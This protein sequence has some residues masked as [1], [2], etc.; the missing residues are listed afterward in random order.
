M[1]TPTD[2]P[3]APTRPGKD[4]QKLLFEP[5][6]SINGPIKGDSLAPFLT[7]VAE[8]RNAQE[9]LILELNTNGG[10]ADIARRIALEIRLFTR[11]SGRDAYCVGKS[12]VYSAGV[13]IFAAFPIKGRFLTEDAVLLIHERRLEKS[14]ALNGPLR[15]NIQIVR[16]QLSLLE[17]ASK[18]ER[19]GFAE[20]V[21][22]SKLSLETLYER[23]TINYYMFAE[24][25]RGLNIIAGI[26]R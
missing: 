8:V 2:F 18:L 7:S 20:L 21:E 14:I 19:E 9:D 1:D 4:S 3:R 5:N 16:E 23:L 12:S 6:V 13:T 10:D 24:E 26:I 25:A 15:A 22:G 17:T 11:H